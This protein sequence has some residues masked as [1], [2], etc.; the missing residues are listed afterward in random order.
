[1]KLRALLRFPA[2]TILSIGIL[3]AA[4]ISPY[5]QAQAQ[6]KAPACDRACLE[7]FVDLYMEALIAHKPAQLA[8]APKA[9]NT[10]DG[11]QLIPGDGFWRTAMAKGS[12]RLFTADTETGD[13]AFLGTMREVPA[14]PVIVMIRL[15]VAN[16][17][18]TEIENLVIRD[19]A[20]ATNLEN[21]GKP[22]EVFSTA[23]PA[24]Q[25]STRAALINTANLY[26]AALQ[27][28][29]GKAVPPFTDDCQRI[30]NGTQTTNN[31]NAN[32]PAPAA[33]AGKGK[34]KGGPPSP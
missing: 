27:N 13:V 14:N 8:I 10:E 24:T 22:N 23:I 32:A 6:T 18:I 30:Q 5:P 20:A 28:N 4:A 25:R 34:G 29:D 7:N 17:Q 3:A 33:A 12:Y 2:P 16:R 31:P 1:M 21:H 9:K 26:Y 19:A 11:V 15:K